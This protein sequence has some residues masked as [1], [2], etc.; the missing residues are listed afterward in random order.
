MTL[1]VLR[2]FLAQRLSSKDALLIDRVVIHRQAASARI[3]RAYT[4]RHEG[5]VKYS[6]GN[7][8]FVGTPGHWGNPTLS[9]NDKAL[10]FIGYNEYS[11]RYYQHHWFAHFTVFE[12]SGIEYALVTWNINGSNWWPEVFHDQCLVP[13]ET[14]PWRVAVPYALL[15]E[16]LLKVASEPAA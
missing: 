8:S 13:D 5:P 7:I 2:S 16:H 1:D 15:E 4:N 10:A 3:L 9:T 11:E 6:T 12:Q 14:K